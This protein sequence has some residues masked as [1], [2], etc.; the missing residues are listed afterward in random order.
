MNK[1]KVGD[2][3]KRRAV[4]G[5]TYYGTVYDFINGRM[6]VDLED[7]SRGVDQGCGHEHV[8]ILLPSDWEFA[9]KT[10]RHEL[11]ITS[12][13]TTTNAVYKLNGEV[14]KTAKAVCCASDTFN[15]NVGAELA[16]NRVLYGTDYNPK[17]VAF[18]TCDKA[19]AKQENKPKHEAV[20]LYCAKE[21]IDCLGKKCLT[22]EKTYTL[23]SDFGL[24]FDNGSTSAYKFN[25]E[26]PRCW[27][28]HLIRTEKRPALVGEW[29]R[30]KKN[31]ANDN[32]GDYREGEIYKIEQNIGSGKGIKKKDGSCAHTY[33]GLYQL[34][35]HEYEVLPDY[36]PEKVEP[37]Y[38]S[39]K[40]ICV[41]STGIDAD[42]YFT[43]GK[44]YEYVDGLVKSNRGKIYGANPRTKEKAMEDY[45]VKFIPYLGEQSC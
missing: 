37:V 26:I 16:I 1:F 21:F 24:T 42:E 28:E 22:K 33:K 12:D 34:L 4:N 2:R 44:I 17:D 30:I 18:P 29:V 23:N 14:E 38:Y 13:G 19:V 10:N 40:V 43:V 6:Y 35:D 20:T 25:K 8:W 41:E 7:K 31:P 9:E 5:E 32:F 27:K 15:F 45:R 39:G 36:Q 11:H 3:V